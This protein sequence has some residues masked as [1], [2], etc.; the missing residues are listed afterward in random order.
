MLDQSTIGRV[1]FVSSLSNI[2][3]DINELKLPME[4][5][6]GNIGFSGAYSLTKAYQ[7][8][9]SLALAI[10]DPYYS[11]VS[12]NPGPI[13]TDIFDIKKYLSDAEISQ[14]IYGTSLLAPVAPY[15]LKVYTKILETISRT[16]DVGASR[17][18]W[19]AL[20]R[21]VSIG[22]HVNNFGQFNILKTLGAYHSNY[23]FAVYDN[24]QKAIRK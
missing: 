20:D 6:A 5:L 9:Y 4:S 3:A 23:I 15:T 22:A 13:F 2:L 1:V 7:L 11:T 14:I 24:T 16:T 10:K 8:I 19:A 18:I 12:V 21:R 17:V